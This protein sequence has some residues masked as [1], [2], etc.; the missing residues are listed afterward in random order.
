MDISKSGFNCQS[1]EIGSKYNPTINPDDGLTDGGG[2]L[3]RNPG[4][5]MTELWCFVWELEYEP[6]LQVCGQEK[7]P[8]V[9]IVNNN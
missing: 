1:W 5:I 2:N 8:T 9:V 7:C 4:K 6:R 3:C